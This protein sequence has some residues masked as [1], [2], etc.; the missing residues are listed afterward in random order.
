MERGRNEGGHRS[1]P[2]A[3]DREPA[4]E[5]AIGDRGRFGIHAVEDV[6]LV[7]EKTARAPNCFHSTM[8]LPF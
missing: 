7:D 2:G 8:N 5:A 1:V 6:V 4:P 3:A